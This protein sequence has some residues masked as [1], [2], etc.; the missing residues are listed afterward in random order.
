MTRRQAV[1]N[2]QRWPAGIGLKAEG[3][4]ADTRLL[5]EIAIS[6]AAQIQRQMMDTRP[7]PMP[8]RSSVCAQRMVKA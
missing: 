6:V 7:T 3:R 1:S 8:T 4:G 5:G 2:S